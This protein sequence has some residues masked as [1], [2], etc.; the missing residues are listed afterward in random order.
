VIDR[1]SALHT[2]AAVRHA[3]PG[4]R[5]V[6]LVRRDGATFSDD[7]PAED[8]DRFAGLVAAT[9]EIAHR[10]SGALDLGGLHT[11]VVRAAEGTVLVTPVGT[12]WALAVVTEPQV[13][14]VL[15]D[16]VLRPQVEHLIALDGGATG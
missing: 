1:Q 3:V 16:R 14:T 2:A 9:A 8:H 5:R 15:L 13:N 7:G 6:A 12:T 11:C 10:T 4:V